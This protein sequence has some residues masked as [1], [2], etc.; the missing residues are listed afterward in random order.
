MA[1]G[2]KFHTGSSQVLCAT[3]QNSV[4]QDLCF[5]ALSKTVWTVPQKAAFILNILNNVPPVGRHLVR[6]LQ[7]ADPK[8]A[9]W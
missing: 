9:P 1:A 8:A 4:P 3:V 7:L 5:P 2:S 6:H